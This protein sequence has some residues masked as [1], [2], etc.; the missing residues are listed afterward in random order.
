MNAEVVQ[1]KETEAGVAPVAPHNLEV[2]A[3]LLASLMLSNQSYHRL[4]GLVKP[5]DFYSAE[6]GAVFT[7]ITELIESGMAANPI[8]V[9]A[10][11]ADDRL[12]YLASICAAVPGI[13]ALTYAE[14]LRDLADRRKI[15]EL[16]WDT[17]QDAARYDVFR[18]APDI[19]SKHIAELHEI[20]AVPE[21]GVKSYA[22]AAASALAAERR[23]L[24]G[25]AEN[26]NG[27]S[28]G[29]AS[30]D[31]VIVGLPPAEI[32][33]LGARPGMGKTALAA[34]IAIN[35]A[36]RGGRVL[37]FSLEM[38]SDQLMSRILSVRTGTSADAARRGALDLYQ[39]KAREDCAADVLPI[40][41]DDTPGLSAPMIAGRA[42]SLHQREPLAL[43]VV[44]HLR[45]I[46][47]MN[48]RNF[49]PKVYEIAE[50]TMML[51]EMAK[52]LSAPVLLLAQLNRQLEQRDD[53]RP[54][55]ADL[56]DSGAIEEDAALVTFLYRHVEYMRREKTSHMTKEQLTAH[57]ADIE[58]AKHEAELIIA[59][60][61]FGPS[62]RTRK[63]HFDEL[64]TGFADG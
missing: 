24:D 23:A 44:D 31:D 27:L 28:T 62:N 33:I 25:E 26:A 36:R 15:V 8:T 20:V 1:F 5:E 14:A 34:S 2:E 46:R 6:G 4:A 13:N 37:F 48:P 40:D 7:A 12:D 19:A 61:R 60:N 43:V 64:T 16:C 52:H 59:K 41:I 38:A 47:A 58:E 11:L 21:Q 55:L 45:L 56:R 30:I 18:S 29:F 9:N 3:G 51:K 17:Y 50:N 10:R 49:Q 63:L 54:N 42:R 53:K 57:E 32:T 35:V 39:M 22:Q